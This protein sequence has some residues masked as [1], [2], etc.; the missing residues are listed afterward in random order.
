MELC[1]VSG[2][3]SAL[4]KTLGA[5]QFAFVHNLGHVSAH[6]GRFGGST[7]LLAAL[8]RA[9]LCPVSARPPEMSTTVHSRQTGRAS[10]SAGAHV[11]Q[12]VLD[13]QNDHRRVR[14]HLRLRH[15][16]DLCVAPNQSGLLQEF[17]GVACPTAPHQSPL[18]NNS[19]PHS[20]I[21]AGCVSQCENR[22]RWVGTSVSASLDAALDL[23]QRHRILH[24]LQSTT[25]KSA[26][27]AA[28]S[29]NYRRALH[30]C[31]EAQCSNRVECT[32]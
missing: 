23:A 24:Y 7:A 21:L 12:I 9:H 30:S 17:L 20:L 16:V 14:A 18:S 1:Q 4:D 8:F 5:V 29:T 15:V 28:N 25:H 26:L 32:L 6:S 10:T 22:C 31:S 3:I 27:F 13:S 19:P 2:D 11:L